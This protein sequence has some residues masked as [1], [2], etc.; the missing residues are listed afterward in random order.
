MQWRTEDAVSALLADQPD[1]DQPDA[2]RPD[3]GP[4]LLTVG[5]MALG[6]TPLG[7]ILAGNWGALLTSV[8]FM[9]VWLA[10]MIW[11]VARYGSLGSASVVPSAVM[12]LAWP[13]IG[14]L[15]AIIR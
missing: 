2:D 12:V 4:W 6:M 15:F 3:L 7:L 8:F 13:G 1:T 9:F 11:V 10:S 14:A 5:V